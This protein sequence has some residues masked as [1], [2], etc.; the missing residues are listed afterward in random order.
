VLAYHFSEM[1]YPDVPKDVEDRHHGLRVVLPRKEFDP[2]LGHELY[3]RYLDEYELADELGLNLM[4]NEHHQTATCLQV[5]APIIA[6]TL[7]RRTKNAK[8]LILGS[9]LPHRKPIRVAEEIAMLDCISGGRVISGFVRGNGTEIQPANTNPVLN[10]ERF[11][12]AHDLIVKAWT[13]EE[14]FNWEGRH[15]HFRYVNPW[16]RTFQ[17]PHP[18]IWITSGSAENVGWIADHQYTFATLLRPRHEVRELFDAYRLRCSERGLPEPGSD[19]FAY[20]CIGHVA[21]TDEQA[22]IEGEQLLWYLRLQRNPPFFL[23]PGF[24]SA[25]R[26][27]RVAKGAFGHPRESWE[28][29]MDM[30]VVIGGSP[31]TVIKQITRLNDEVGGLGHL[32]MMNQAGFMPTEQVQKSLKPFAA[33]VYPAIKQLSSPSIQPEPASKSAAR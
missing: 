9:P 24:A 29:L 11:E 22:S 16:P 6:A 15:F 4:F 1:P 32:M 28:Q 20:L 7:A 17:Q 5:N 10:R 8:L 25:S 19:K 12:E 18:P 27:A 2:R 21:E 33:E 30:G 26:L 14:A 31:D 3:N 13:A 23:P